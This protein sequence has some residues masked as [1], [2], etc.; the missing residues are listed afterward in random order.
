MGA[1]VIGGRSYRALQWVLA[2][3]FRFAPGRV[4]FSV[5]LCMLLTASEGASVLL[6][7][8]L[9]ELIGAT[10]ENPLP[11]TVA[12]LS[13]ALGWLH[14]EPTLGVVLVLFVVL[15]VTRATAA[16][17]VTHTATVVR[18]GLVDRHRVRLYQA[19]SQAEWTY[20]LTRPPSGFHHL[21]TTEVARIGWIV[22]HLTETAVVSLTLLAYIALALRLSWPI[23]LLV[24]SVAGALGWVLRGTL[25]RASDL[26]ADS[27]AARLQLN[28]A[29]TAHL[30]SLKT[31]R[32]FGA[33]DRQAEA[34]RRASRVLAHATAASADGES[35]LQQQLE[36]SSTLLLAVIVWVMVMAMQVH[37][38]VLLVLLYIFARVMPRLNHVY[39]LSQ[40]IMTW[41]PSVEAV[42]DME[43]ECAAATLPA[44][45]RVVTVD[46]GGEVVVESVEFTYEHGQASTRALSG[47]HIRVAPGQTTAII[48]AS[49]SG[50][51]TLADILAGLLPPASGRV[52]IG[53]IPLSV[54]SMASWRSAI[55]YVPQDTFLF[56]DT[57]RANLL[58]AHPEASDDELWEALR[59]AAADT[60]VAALPHGLDTVVGDRG[61]RVSG[62]ERQRLAIARALVRRP[63]VLILDE[64]TSALDLDSEERIKAAIDAVHNRL[65]VILITHRVSAAR[66]AD[67]IFVLDKG[68]V[69]A[70]GTWDQV[71]ALRPSLVHALGVER[72][73]AAGR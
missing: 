58:W 18:E 70:S 7:P 57:I 67:R 42:R 21:V 71:M 56:D 46:G 49:G 61:V 13:A 65:T 14:L 68:R 2:E 1:G 62:G 23:T 47:V 15:S 43:E 52:L 34:F 69:S 9:L 19:I 4:V 45:T 53:G 27:A 10:P 72:G 11:R 51:T 32:G 5:L 6:M 60:F 50:K 28:A 8:Q 33:M 17:I 59:L 24:L 31:A 20:L 44:A 26:G 63:Q 39:R 25:T 40:G 16:R 37:S 30:A 36:V 35:Q 12:W 29:L 41:L 3:M 22:T 64:A 48:G 73:A 55:G 38:G 66:N 54:D